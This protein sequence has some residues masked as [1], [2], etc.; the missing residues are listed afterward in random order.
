MSD[1]LGQERR[2]FA[3]LLRMSSIGAVLLAVAAALNLAV[4]VVIREHF[5]PW[6]ITGPYTYVSLLLALERASAGITA[7]GWIAVCGGA[8]LALMRACRRSHGNSLTTDPWITV[9][10]F[11]S[12]AAA[13]NVIA[14]TIYFTLLWN[15]SVGWLDATLGFQ[16]AGWLAI[17]GALLAYV[18]AAR[19]IPIERRL[20]LGL[21]VGGFGAVLLASSFVLG[22]AFYEMWVADLGLLVRLENGL[23]AA[24]W[25]A[26]AAGSGMSAI[27]A[28]KTADHAEGLEIEWA[29]PIETLLL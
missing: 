8:V 28:R 13:A 27:G 7:A 17:A 11:A 6:H 12:V 1:Q 24:G 9:L 29:E 20:L 14:N 26:L 10:G 23:A 2:H 15:Y 18:F 5:P 21:R 3:L 19:R 16:A 25:L 4:V 22:I